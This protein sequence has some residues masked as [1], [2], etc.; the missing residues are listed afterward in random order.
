MHFSI[1]S[2]FVPSNGITVRSDDLKLFNKNGISLTELLKNQTLTLGVLGSRSYGRNLDRIIKL[3]RE[4]DNVDELYIEDSY[5]GL[6]NMLLL[7]RVDYVLGYA[8]EFGYKLRKDNLQNRIRFLSVRE[9]GDYG[10][11]HLVCSKT[12]QGHNIITKVNKVLLRMRPTERYRSFMEKWIDPSIIPE[13]RKK[14]N[15]VFLKTVE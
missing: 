2:S 5:S 9:A 3:H 12:P 8:L 13:Y 11:S 15:D 4:E 7:G 10:M 6:V 14:Y 1:P